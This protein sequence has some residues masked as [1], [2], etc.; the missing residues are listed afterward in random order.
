[1]EL[2]N[3]SKKSLESSH[4]DLQTIFYHVNK[5][6]DFPFEVIYGHRTPDEQF[7]LYK[8]GRK[9][10]GNTWVVIDRKQVVTN[11]DGFLKKS[12]HNAFPSMAVDALP[13]PIN[14]KKTRQLT[15]YAGVVMGI[16]EMLYD[17]GMI[18]HKLRWGGDWN[19]NNDP[20]DETFVD[21][22]HFELYKPKA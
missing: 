10:Q 4:P 21:Q 20:E 3:R 22:P 8:K 1:M 15:Y 2:S 6:I 11:C 7:E 16:A 19:E 17:M 12:N 5:T 18:T 9:K 14:W 13:L